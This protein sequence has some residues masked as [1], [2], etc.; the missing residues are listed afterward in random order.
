MTET[1]LRKL[2]EAATPDIVDR[3]T[4]SRNGC[5]SEEC[6]DC[7]MLADAIAELTALRAKVKSFDPQPIE[8]LPR[9]ATVLLWVCAGPENT[10]YAEDTKGQWLTFY[11]DD[12]GTI[13]NAETWKPDNTVNSRHFKATAF[14]DPTGIP[15]PL[16]RAAEAYQEQGK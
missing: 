12:A 15:A 1:E 13:C 6:L 11:I 14:I 2:A 8:A 7:R 10:T 3:L 4:A 16:R 9:D 5:G